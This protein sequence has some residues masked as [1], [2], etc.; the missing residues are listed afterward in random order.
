MT[1]A[2]C[3][4]WVPRGVPVIPTRICPSPEQLIEALA[5]DEG[6]VVVKPVVS[7]GSADTGRFDPGDPKALALGR[8]ILGHGMPVMVQPAVPS[9]ATEGEVSAVLFGGGLSHAF[10]KGPML[11]LGGA[12]IDGYQSLEKVV[13]TPQQDQV[14]RR[15][16]DAVSRIGADQLGVSV[17]PLYARVDL[18]RTEK[19]DDVVLEV[20]LN[21]PSFFLTLDA[22]AADRFAA[23]V[24]REAGAAPASG[25]G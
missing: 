2:I 22:G 6:E 15:S 17:P 18:V 12:V 13:L 1:S 7:A 9:V 21:E 3:F 11:A 20:E 10:R 25:G 4:S 5:A 19:G 8:R 24:R 14:V 16:V 23:A